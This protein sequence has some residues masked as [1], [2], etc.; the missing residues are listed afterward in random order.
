M[1]AEE[2]DDTS[3]SDIDESYFV[4]GALTI[5]V[6]TYDE[7]VI[8]DYRLT[9]YSNFPLKCTDVTG[10]GGSEPGES[11]PNL[12]LST[13]MVKNRRQKTKKVKNRRK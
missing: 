13:P 7:D 4:D 12:T 3:T 8:A 1:A 5:M 10:S 9:V 11:L 6:C 2:E